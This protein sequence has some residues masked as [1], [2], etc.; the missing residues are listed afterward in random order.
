MATTGQA[1]QARG[2]D[3]EAEARA[4]L[5]RALGLG[6]ALGVGLLAPFPVIRLVAL[7]LSQADVAVE[8]GAA[9]YF[10]ARI[11]GAPAALTGFGILG[12]L[13]GMGR[14]RALLAYQVVL[15][16]LNAVLDAV[17]VGV[18][19]W[20][21]AGIGAGTALAEWT[22]LGFGLWLVRDGFR[23]FAPLFDPGRLAAMFTANRDILVRTLAL[24]TAFA[25]FVNAG[26][27]TD[28][29]AQ[30]GNQVLL[31]FVAVSAFVL[32]AFA[33]VAE[34]EGGEAFGARDPARLRRAMAVT[35]GLA[36]GF[37]A[38]FAI[39]T[40][41]VGPP[42]IRF[43]V[44]DADA[45]GAALAFLPYCALV[46]LIGVPAWQLDGIFLGATRG[47]ALRNAAIAATGLYLATDW[48][49][50]PYGNTGVWIAFV[51]MYAYRALALAVGLPGLLRAVDDA[52]A[53]G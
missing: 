13:L 42:I 27:R 38:L 4:V 30:A 50:W 48:L 40:A 6:A 43:F 11:W 18:F 41:A 53:G 3:E 28:A 44:A 22:A 16:G 36:L 1:A 21:P 2:G 29:A 23:G 15:N 17:F 7:G 24:L 49:L 31:Q 52:E 33:F 37:G 26:A 32:D 39:G 25:W 20:G 51:A 46:P 47:R 9:A 12:W 8:A 45:R 5:V 19:D 35:T 10:D 14:T 34:K